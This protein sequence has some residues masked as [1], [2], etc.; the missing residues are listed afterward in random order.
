MNTSKSICPSCFEV[1]RHKQIVISAAIIESYVL[2]MFPIFNITISAA[3]D[4]LRYFM[5]NLLFILRQYNTQY[6]FSDFFVTCLDLM[7]LKEFSQSK[8]FYWSYK[9]NDIFHI[10]TYSIEFFR[11]NWNYFL[12]LVNVLQFLLAVIQ[13]MNKK[14]F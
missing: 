5:T 10:R 8:M 14:S 6:S 9:S 13:A 11:I 4:R 3:N 7:T 1:P 12:S 2:C